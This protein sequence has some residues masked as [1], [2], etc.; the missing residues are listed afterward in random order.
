MVDN[1][2]SDQT[3]I[4]V[5]VLY[6]TINQISDVPI[7][8]TKMVCIMTTS[9]S[10]TRESVDQTQVS[11]PDWI[12]LSDMPLR[13]QLSRG[14]FQRFRDPFPLNSRMNDRKTDMHYKTIDKDPRSHEIRHSI[15]PIGQHLHRADDRYRPLACPIH[16]HYM[17][18]RY[19]DS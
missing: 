12:A 16:H 7:L 17:P 10:T 5:R 14:A 1:P 8:T 3:L 9:R 13:G 11:I 2:E 18:K 19:N 6:S 4:L 15:G